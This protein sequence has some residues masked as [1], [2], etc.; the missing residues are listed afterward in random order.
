M[1]I[2]IIGAGNVGTSLGSGWAKAGHQIIYGV[3]NPQDEKARQ[4]KAEAAGAEVTTYADAARAAE[5]VVISTRWGATEAAVRAC[6][7]L[8]GKTVIDVTNPLKSDISGLDCGFNTSGGEQ[9]AQWANGAEVFK[10]MNQV[11]FNLMD[12]PEFRSGL[13]PVMLVAGNGVG[14]AKVLQLVSDLGFEAI[15][16]GGL[17]YARL[18]EPLAMLWIHLAYSKEGQGRDFAFSLLRK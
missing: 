4:L 16:A 1:K 7:N 15:E 10:T 18:L 17:E 5:V 9:V 13:K 8:R 6:G 14:K 11:G 2:A 3:R 12:H